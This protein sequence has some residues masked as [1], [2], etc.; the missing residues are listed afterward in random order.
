MRIEVSI[1]DSDDRKKYLV[2][3]IIDDIIMR[4]NDSGKNEII[5]VGI[6]TDKSTLDCLGC[7]VGTFI[8]SECKNIKVYGTLQEPIHALN[9]K[10]K[11]DYIFNNHKN[12]FII[13]VD[14]TLG[15]T[16]DFLKTIYKD[17]PIKP[18]AGVGKKLPQVGDVSFNYVLGDCETSFYLG[19]SNFRLSD[20]W[21]GARFIS[22]ILISLDKQLLTKYKNIKMVD[23]IT[24]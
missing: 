18:G 3:Q 4:F 8:H 21:T 23:N 9:M 6:G 19:N 12:S 5:F 10:S 1:L 13:G 7:L 2:G 22:D 11:L 17:K 16:D 15:N 14:A 20:T 24:I